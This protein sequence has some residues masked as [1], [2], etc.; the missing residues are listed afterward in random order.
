MSSPRLRGGFNDLRRQSRLYIVLRASRERTSERAS[1]RP[2]ERATFSFAH[3]LEN[4]RSER[5]GVFSMRSV[6]LDEGDTVGDSV[7]GSFF[8]FFLNDKE[9]LINV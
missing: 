1:E 4:D 9:A 2:S 5:H 7:V 6:P 8:F 3:P